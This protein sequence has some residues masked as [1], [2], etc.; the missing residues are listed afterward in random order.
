MKIDMKKLTEEQK[1]FY[2]KIMKLGKDKR[3]I[4]MSYDDLFAVLDRV[5]FC[6]FIDACCLDDQARKILKKHLEDKK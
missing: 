1:W 5:K 3:V 6:Y 4:K 2:S